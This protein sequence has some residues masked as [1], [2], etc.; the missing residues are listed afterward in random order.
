MMVPML[1]CIIPLERELPPLLLSPLA[2][3]HMILLSQQ[4]EDLVLC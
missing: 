1:R 3:N 2:L 4:G